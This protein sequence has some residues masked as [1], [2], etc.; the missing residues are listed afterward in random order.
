LP[1][2]P[3]LL[4]TPPKTNR[5]AGIE[6]VNLSRLELEID[7]RVLAPLSATLVNSRVS[8]ASTNKRLLSSVV[9]LQG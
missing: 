9:S 8:I 2:D 4:S 6:F 7:P 5:N 3:A 1:P